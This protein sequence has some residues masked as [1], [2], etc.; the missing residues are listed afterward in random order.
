MA[1]VLVSL[2]FQLAFQWD[3]MGFSGTF[4]RALLPAICQCVPLFCAHCYT[5]PT[6]TIRLE[7]WLHFLKTNN[8]NT[9]TMEIQTQ[10]IL[11]SSEVLQLI[12][13]KFND[14]SSFLMKAQLIF[15]KLWV[16]GRARVCNSFEQSKL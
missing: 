9:P 15:G 10:Q 16:K 1:D 14:S 5:I 13:R 4:Q 6:V 12:L 8:Q 11:R 3:P 2:Y 7:I